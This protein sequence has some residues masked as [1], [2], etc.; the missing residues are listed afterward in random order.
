GTRHGACAGPR[1]WSCTK[2]DEARGATSS[3]ETRDEGGDV[4]GRGRCWPGRAHPGRPRGRRGLVGRC[5]RRD[6]DGIPGP[7][8]VLRESHAPRLRDLRSEGGPRDQSHAQAVTSRGRR[9]GSV[10][11]WLHVLGP[12]L[13]T[14]ASDDDPSGITTYSVAGAALR[15]A[16]LWTALATFPLMA[17]VQLTCA[18]IGLV[19][20]RGLVG[21]VRRHYP[22]SFLCV[23]CLLLLVANV[24]N[25]A[26]DLGGLSH[27]VT[28]LPGLPPVLFVPPVGAAIVAMKIWASYAAVAAY[29]KWLTVVLFAYIVAGFPAK[30]DWGAALRGTIVPQISLDRAFVATLVGI[31]GTT[32]SPY[33]FFWQT[34][35]EVEEERARGRDSIAARRGA[36]PDELRDARLDVTTGM[37]LSNAV[38]YFIMLTTASTL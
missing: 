23:A 17:A 28:L 2:R 24:F 30:P 10:V 4:P 22:R 7:R 5:V 26:A 27:V 19:T 14:G 12:G 33:L 1:P 25:I 37:L 20:G 18:R 38:M 6:H 29:L 16:T 36:T 35:L 21:C 15:Y 31:L 11:R 3:K 8:G 9:A 13:I 34:S 32:I